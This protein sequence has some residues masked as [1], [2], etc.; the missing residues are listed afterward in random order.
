MIFKGYRK[1]L[2]PQDMWSLDIQNT[3]DYIFRRFN[4][5]WSKM[6]ERND[7]KTDSQ[8]GT[9]MKAYIKI[10][11]PLLKCFWWQLFVVSAVKLI[12]SCLAFINPLVL[13]RLISFMSPSNAEPQWRGFFYASLM[14]ITPMFESLLNSQ[15][16]YRV[17]L[18]A[19]RIRATLISIIYK[20]V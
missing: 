5:I 4:K 16:E 19:M 15:Y 20:K 2:T 9:Q 12:S 14:F 8:K 17:N 3:T 13:D 11:G 10:L 18:V 6:S 7:K 1:P